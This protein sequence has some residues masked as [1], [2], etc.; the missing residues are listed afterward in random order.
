MSNKYGPTRSDLKF[1]L[2]F[3]VVGLGLVGA[4]LVYRGVPTSAGG[5]EAIGIGIAFFGGTL[6]WTL[7]KLIKG[8]HS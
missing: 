1:R 8:D 5:W 2:A 3:S 7:R 6:A 4:A